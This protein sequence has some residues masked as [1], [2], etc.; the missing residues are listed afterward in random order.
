MSDA[1]EG[2]QGHVTQLAEFRRNRQKMSKKRKAEEANAPLTAEER[3]GHVAYLQAYL[4]AIGD[5]VDAF[6]D[7]TP[8]E[9][10]EVIDGMGDGQPG[11]DWAAG[12]Y[13]VAAMVEDALKLPA[14][15]A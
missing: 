6:E 5:A 11:S 7:V 10:R 15:P 1:D 4:R 13:D 2:A 9:L 14:A 8:E 3:G 12:V